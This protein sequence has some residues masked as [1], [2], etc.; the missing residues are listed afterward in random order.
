[1]LGALIE[2][3]SSFNGSLY[4]FAY[5]LGGIPFGY[6]LAKYI[7][8]VDIKKEGS[9]NIGATN[10]LRVLK[11]RDPNLAKKLGALTLALDAL[12]GAIAVLVAKMLGANDAVVW[13]VGVFAVIGH[14]YTPFLKFEGG[15]G[16]A[17]SLGVLIVLIPIP[18]IIALIIWAISAKVLKISSLSSLIALVAL[19]I[20]A[21]LIYKNGLSGINSF[22]P[23]YIIAFI[24]FY[25]H[26]P[27]IKRLLAKE[28][29][30]VV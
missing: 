22:V 30:K 16:V 8:K 17:T 21:N 24:V 13:G 20:S 11:K 29:G 27:N 26:I 15:K 12:K 19:L 5:L 10:V 6:L 14:C 7:G 9:G 23:L 4:L 25:K 28:E 1:M 3:F 18:T 2:L